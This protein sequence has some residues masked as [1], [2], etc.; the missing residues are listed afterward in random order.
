MSS[1]WS[2]IA[3]IHKI[4]TLKR[5]ISP[6]ALWQF[7]PTRLKLLVLPNAG[8]QKVVSRA[9]TSRPSIG[10]LLHMAG[11]ERKQL[12]AHGSIEE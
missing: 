12:S 9:S 6:E 7:A 2:P 8:H 1:I 11:Y 3:I 5:H 4:A 10:C